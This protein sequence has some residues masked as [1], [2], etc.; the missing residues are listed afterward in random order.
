M[1]TSETWIKPF[2]G[3]MLKRHRL[4]AKYLTQ[5]RD[6]FSHKNTL[7]T[8]WRYCLAHRGI[9]GMPH[10][11][12]KAAISQ[13]RFKIKGI[14]YILEECFAGSC[15]RCWPETRGI[16]PSVRLQLSWRDKPGAHLRVMQARK[17]W[18]AH[19]FQ[20]NMAKVQ[21][22]FREEN[23]SSSFLFVSWAWKDG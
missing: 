4:P 3:R 13:P 21:W 11:S 19:T 8:D 9:C 18:V 5:I 10:Q 17:L 14:W 6:V 2:P 22:E 15:P 23:N 1:V 12:H 16:P 20:Q 7:F